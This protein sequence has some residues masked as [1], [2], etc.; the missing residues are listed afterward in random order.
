MKKLILLFSIVTLTIS[1]YAQPEMK[2]SAQDHDFGTFKEEAG[3]QSYDFLVTN[4]GNAPLVIQKIVTSC[5][6]TN[7]DWT[8]EPIPAGGKGKITARYDPKDRPGKFNK[9]LSVY[10]NSKPEIVVMAIRG[11]VVPR[12]KT[13]EDLYTFPVGSVR[14]ESNHL[15]F[16]NI[17]KTE[18][19]IRVMQLIN[20]SAVPVK[21]EFDQLPVHLSLKA[22]PETL[23]PGQ[24]GIIEGTFDATKNPGWGNLSDMVKIKLNGVVQENVYYYVSVNLVEDFSSLSKEDLENAPVFKVD[25]TTVDLGKMPGSTAKEVEFKFTNTGKK[26][27]I[28]RHVRSTCGCTAVQQGPKGV[29]FKPG[30]SGSIKAVFNSGGYKGKVTKVIYVYSNDPKNS[31][32][33]LML[34][35]DVEQPAAT[36]R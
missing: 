16:T 33:A 22:T 29:G 1:L 25:A 21:V 35:A 11:E 5:G 20:T 28:L 15:A 8:R 14:F 19:K 10:T 34:T 30:E 18:K 6:C 4:T 23:K 24:K 27:L 31:E 2:L 7:P 3:P 12:E 9:T 32:V 13:V 36:A 17:K 26:D